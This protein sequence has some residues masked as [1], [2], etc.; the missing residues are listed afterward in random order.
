MV[1]IRLL[2][3]FHLCLPAE[4]M[5]VLAESWARHGKG[6][7]LI[8]DWR[9]HALTVYTNTLDKGIFSVA[10]TILAMLELIR[11]LRGE[12]FETFYQQV[13]GTGHSLGA[14][15][16]GILGNRLRKKFDRP[17]LGIIYA[18]DPAGLLLISTYN[19]MHHDDFELLTHRSAHLVIVLHTTRNTGMRFV[20]GDYD[21]YAYV[22]EGLEDWCPKNLVNE[23]CEHIRAPNIFRAAMEATEHPL[24]GFKCHDLAAGAAVRDQEQAVFGLADPKGNRFNA[25]Y[26]P[27]GNKSPYN[28]VPNRL[29]RDM[30]T[31]TI[32]KIHPDGKLKKFIS[33]IEFHSVKKNVEKPQRKLVKSQKKDVKRPKSD[34]SLQENDDK[35]QRNDAKQQTND[36]KQPKE[37]V[38]AKESVKSWWKKCIVQTPSPYPV[39]SRWVESKSYKNQL[40]E[41]SQAFEGKLTGEETQTAEEKQTV[42]ETKTAEEKQTVEENQTVSEVAPPTA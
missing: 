38:Y 33:D 31:C 24:I 35:Q 17:L 8:I 25:Y 2:T 13:H 23:Q 19:R 28:Y 5:L 9:V 34:D 27:I 39:R 20:I 6:N 14:Q 30:K 32:K 11:T 40:M 37:E 3:I 36:D 16:F 15:I 10:G 7:V 26:L 1:P 18:L 41:P 12:S 4:W 21:F 29:E 42:E 22:A